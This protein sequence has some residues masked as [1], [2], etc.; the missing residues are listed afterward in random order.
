ML[1][2]FHHIWGGINAPFLNYVQVCGFWGK[3]HHQ[4]E[5]I[6]PSSYKKV[7]EG[8]EEKRKS[9]SR[10][11]DSS[12]TWNREAS[13]TSHFLSFLFIFSVFY[14][15]SCCISLSQYYE[16]GHDSLNP[17]LGLRDVDLW[18]TFVVFMN[19]YEVFIVIIFVVMGLCQWLVLYEYCCAWS[20]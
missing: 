11:E 20:R 8:L 7:K 5:H 4:E 10:F 17:L 13:S 2:G 19:G 3:N 18:W 6:S 9:T 14:H 12:T 16:L 1:L 15:E